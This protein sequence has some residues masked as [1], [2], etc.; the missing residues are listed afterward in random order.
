[1]K[2][3]KRKLSSTEEPNGN[4][5]APA[6]EHAAQPQKKARVDVGS[7]SSEGHMNAA[8]TSAPAVAQYA[9]QF[10]SAYPFKHLVLPDMFPKE[11]LQKVR[12]QVLATK[13]VQ[14]RNDLYDFQQSQADLK[15]EHGAGNA[16]ATL[17][18]C[19][20]SAPFR[21]WLK[22]VTGIAT[23]DTVDMS[24]AKYGDGSYLLCHDDDLSGR[25]IAFILYLVPEE[26]SALD[27]GSLDL[28]SVDPHTAMPDRVVRT[29]TPSF[30]AFAFFEVSPVSFHQVAEVLSAAKGPRLSI[31]G[32]FHGKP[33]ARPPP[34]K[35]PL[36]VFVTPKPLED[37]V[38]DAGDGASGSSVPRTGRPLQ[39][40]VSSSSLVEWLNPQYLRKSVLNAAAQQYADM[41]S[42]QLSDFL[43]EDKYKAVM[44]AMG[45]QSWRHKGPAIMCNH[46]EAYSTADTGSNA[47]RNDFRSGILPDA[48]F[49]LY[50]LLTSAPFMDLLRLL[51][52]TPLEDVAGS[53]RCFGHGDYTLI[54]DSQYQED[55]K[56]AKAERVFGK[57]SS[58]AAD[59]AEGDDVDGDAGDVAA[60]AMVDATFC[61]VIDGDAW[62]DECGGYVSYLS[63][64]EELLSVPPAPNTL[65]LV[66]RDATV[67]S[68][69]KYVTHKAPE[70]R[71]DVAL[72]FRSAE[73][74]AEDGDEEDEEEED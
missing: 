7:S 39:L 40:D 35:P 21:A 15:L 64:D 11:L 45:A 51:T 30:G 32:W 53:V 4:R 36:T 61:C 48:V 63:G 28:F 65:A 5:A 43:R 70:C 42:L 62:S 18:D 12:K 74:D 67:M 9:S 46:R 26:W 13:Y 60:R 47:D 50:K 19:I 20:Y 14:K 71:Y 59:S 37:E 57:A 54:T 29:I 44:R 22:G 56:K 2:A 25:V 1:M 72:Q 3:A 27:G 31:S 23:N 52:G 49:H 34:P 66:A 55:K 69:V 17:R 16:V 8:H 73:Q 6:A 38:D 10:A 68:F 33:F 24:A 58:A 41:G